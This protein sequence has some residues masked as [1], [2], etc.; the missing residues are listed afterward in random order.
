MDVT[1]PLPIKC[2]IY[3]KAKDSIVNASVFAFIAIVVIITLVTF[4]VGI[5]CW[6]GVVF[7]NDDIIGK[8]ILA[9]CGTVMIA[10]AYILAV[11]LNDEIFHVNIN[12]RC[13][14]DE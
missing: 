10:I 4:N 2:S 11:L 1:I 5:I 9:M 3:R 7:T 14:R 13:I 6:Y 12:V 8:S